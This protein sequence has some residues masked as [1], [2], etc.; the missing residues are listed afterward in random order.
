MSG[1]KAVGQVKLGQKASMAILKDKHIHPVSYD[2]RKFG[3][4]KDQGYVALVE[5]LS[6]AQ[7]D[8]L[9]LVGGGSFQEQIRK[10]FVQDGHGSQ[11]YEIC[12]TKEKLVQEVYRRKH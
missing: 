10:R 2:P 4:I 9:V 8:T 6:M 5:Q 11:I 12:H 3:G 7:S 1:C